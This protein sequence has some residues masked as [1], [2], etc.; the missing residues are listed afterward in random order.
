[1]RD[2]VLLEELEYHGSSEHA[3][4]PAAEEE[5]VLSLD[6]VGPI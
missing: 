3:E 6:D 1:M 2:V 5:G 4:G